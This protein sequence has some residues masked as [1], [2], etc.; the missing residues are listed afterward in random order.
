MVSTLKDIDVTSLKSNT[1]ET[2]ACS[3]VS[4]LILPTFGTAIA[5]DVN[6]VEPAA[7]LTWIVVVGV[8]L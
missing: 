4:F 5:V 7:E 2:S 6:T 8:K 3:W 1:I